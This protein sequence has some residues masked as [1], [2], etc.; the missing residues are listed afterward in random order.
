MGLRSLAT[1]VA[2]IAMLGALSLFEG[3]GRTDAATALARA[4]LINPELRARLLERAESL[5]SGSWSGVTY[6]HGGAAEIA[7]W[8]ASLRSVEG[9]A[10][11]GARAAR[12]GERAVRLA[13]V[14]PITWM[15]LAA[16]GKSGEDIGACAPAQ[17]LERSWESAAVI[18]P[19]PGCARVQVSVAE[20]LMPDN[21]DPRFGAYVTTLRDRRHA[22]NCF[23]ALAP[24]RSFQQLLRLQAPEH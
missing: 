23:G 6:W 3:V 19:E 13:P 11:A 8:I 24:Q 18:E 2:A 12:A 22:V 17:C 20:G 10:D 15:R 14:Q 5:T 9:S 21:D 4:A 7:S 16:L 1:M